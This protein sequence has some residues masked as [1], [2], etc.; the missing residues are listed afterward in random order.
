MLETIEKDMSL[1]ITTG[2]STTFELIK[3]KVEPLDYDLARDM[4]RE[5]DDVDE[6]IISNTEIDIRLSKEQEKAAFAITQRI[7]KEIN[8]ALDMIENKELTR[9]EIL[10][11]STMEEIGEELAELIFEG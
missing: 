3:D 5:L 2:L 4:Y 7:I 8:F 6:I 10:D 1:A 11:N 9:E